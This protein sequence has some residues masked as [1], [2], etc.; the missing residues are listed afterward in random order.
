MFYS[1]QILVHQGSQ[2]QLFLFIFLFAFLW[3]IENIAGSL[4]KYKKWKHATT[5]APFIFTISTVFITPNLHHV[6]HHFEKPY[7]DCNYGDVFSFWDRLF[8]TFR[9]LPR[10]LL[11]FGLD[12]HNTS[13]REKEFQYF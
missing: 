5:N 9:R 8:G 7:T 2:L 13:Q 3:N 10:E 1:K 4:M 12:T 11:T 6:H